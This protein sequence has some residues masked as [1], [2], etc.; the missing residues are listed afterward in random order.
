MKYHKIIILA[1]ADQDG[2]HIRAILL[3]FFFRYY[4]SL[5]TDGH[6]YIAQ[7]PLYSIKKA[8]NSFGRIRKSNWQRQK[9]KMGRGA[10]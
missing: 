7:P 1:D 3:T 9:K 2:A 5:I 6:V 10:K 4:R 8:N